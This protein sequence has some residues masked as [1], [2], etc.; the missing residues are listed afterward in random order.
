ME[1]LKDEVQKII[2]NELMGSEKK[3][4]EIF[5]PETKG[6]IAIRNIKITEGR[7]SIEEDMKV[8]GKSLDDGFYSQVRQK[9]N[10]LRF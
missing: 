5:L 10:K 2:Q 4:I 1:E 9:I 6:T 3:W 8:A 7:S